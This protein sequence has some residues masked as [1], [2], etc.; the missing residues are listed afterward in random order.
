MLAAAGGLFLLAAP[1]AAENAMP[2]PTKQLESTLPIEPAVPAG[3]SQAELFERSLK[4]RCG[5]YRSPLPFPLVNRLQENANIQGPTIELTHEGVRLF[6]RFVGLVQLREYLETSVKNYELLHPGENLDSIMV[7]AM[8]DVPGRLLAGVLGEFLDFGLRKVRLV[9]GY[10]ETFRRPLLGTI[11]RVRLQ[12]TT[13]SF[14]RIPD[15]ARVRDH[16]DLF[17]LSEYAQFRDLVTALLE[18]QNLD[19]LGTL[20]LGKDS[21]IY[22]WPDVDKRAEFE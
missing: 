5:M 9:T 2:W 11:S 6:S 13:M 14:E 17:V 12:T 19:R 21:D 8:P 22:G 20:V 4:A 10:P 16:A 7:M 18:R 15:S 1:L 3:L